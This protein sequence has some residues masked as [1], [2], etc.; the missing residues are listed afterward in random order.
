MT[1]Q[2]IKLTKPV[3]FLPKNLQDSWQG[4]DALM[5]VDEDRIIINRVRSTPTLSEL[6]PALKEIGK[7]ITQKDIDDAV[8]EVRAEQK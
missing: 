7:D 5:S 8:R 3:D 2:T 4:V 6:K 1:T